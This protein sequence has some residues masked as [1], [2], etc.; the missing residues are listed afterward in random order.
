[1]NKPIFKNKITISEQEAQI[2]LAESVH[3]PWYSNYVP[4]LEEWIKETFTKNNF[5]TVDFIDLP[6]LIRNQGQ[7][8]NNDIEET[9]YFILKNFYQKLRPCQLLNQKTS[10]V[11]KKEEYA[12]TFKDI[13]PIIYKCFELGLPTEAYNYEDI[14]WITYLPNYEQISSLYAELTNYL[15]EHPEAPTQAQSIR[16]QAH[17]IKDVIGKMTG[18]YKNEYGD[19]FYRIDSREL[20]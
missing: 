16:K 14:T 5:V 4:E 12:T 3:R 19:H 13:Y 11:V 17:K 15:V 9:N 6:F 20:Y 1:M 2:I 7:Y 10:I 8:I 18:L